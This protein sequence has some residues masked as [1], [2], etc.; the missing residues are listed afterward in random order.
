[1]VLS[2]ALRFL[3]YFV[4]ITTNDANPEN[5]VCSLSPKQHQICHHYS[6]NNIHTDANYLPY[7]QS[8]QHNTGYYARQSVDVND[9]TNYITSVSQWSSPTIE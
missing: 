6:H 7:W 9:F 2:S 8:V 4:T 1:M 3:L 5:E